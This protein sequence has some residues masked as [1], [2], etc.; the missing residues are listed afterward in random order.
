MP[1]VNGE[2]VTPA[3]ALAKGLCPEC[4]ADFKAENA[5]AHLNSHWQAPIPVDKRGD[6][7]RKRQAMLQKHVTEQGVRTSNMP[8][9]AASKPADLP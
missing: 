3:A 5:I 4:G 8:P 2:L 9:P 6:G 7:A 1:L